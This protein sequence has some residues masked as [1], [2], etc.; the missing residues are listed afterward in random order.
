MAPTG[1]DVQLPCHLRPATCGELA[2]LTQLTHLRL[3]GWAQ[4]AA[5]LA[6]ALC[7]LTLLHSL[8]LERLG[9]KYA[10]PGLAE[11]ELAAA[12][13]GL[14]R[15]TTLG[16][17]DVYCLRRPPAVLAQLPRLQN[18]QVVAARSWRGAALPPGP[19]IARLRRLACDW[20]LLWG[21][22]VALAPAATPFLEHLLVEFTHKELRRKPNKTPTLAAFWAWLWTWA[23]G[24]PALRLLQLH[25]Q[26]DSGVRRWR[27]WQGGCLQDCSLTSMP[28]L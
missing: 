13:G 23:S 15:L 20:P 28:P 5:S 10:P 1:R 7:A 17:F 27:R 11:G 2:R 4:V 24:H 12:L 8:H 3:R 9:G 6:D 14:A 26:D 18:L 22:H 21:S 19:W 16:L 25:E